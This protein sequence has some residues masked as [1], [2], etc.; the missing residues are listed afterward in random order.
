MPAIRTALIGLSATAKTSWAGDAHLPYLLSPIGRKHYDVVALL[1]SSVAAGEASKQHFKLHATV[2]TYGDPE[3]LAQDLDIDLVVCCTRADVH[4]PTIAPSL[5]AGK[6]AFIEWPLAENSDKARE[7]VTM[8][9][10]SGTNASKCIIGLQGRVAPPTLI[11][12]ELLTSGTIGT[13]LSSSVASFGHLLPRDSLPESLA[14]FADR[15]VG[16]NAIVI[17]NGHTLDYVHAVLGEFAN[18]DA[19]MQIQRPTLS[20]VDAE[21]NKS[22]SLA[23]SVPDLVSIHGSLRASTGDIKV[24]DGATLSQ[25]FRAGPPFKS[26][27]AVTWTINGTKGE[28]MI[29]VQGQYL[30]S[31]SVDPIT[32]LHHDHATNEVKEVQWDW[33]EWQKE[34]P[35]RARIIAEVYERYAEWWEGGKVE[36]RK[37]REWPSLEDAVDRMEE[38]AE[39]FG[40]FDGK[41]G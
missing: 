2:K 32:I 11:V 24:A 38:F 18:F 1:N 10:D 16:G 15:K 27:P 9:K 31:H 19:R 40:Q 35:V 6:I 7:L 30:H 39:M 28:L 21:D 20:L 29:T 17:E 33:S 13:V 26:Q 12:K 25:I 4:F 23:T 41:S 3:A 22:G 34:L 37:G 5:R 8:A 14:Y 36:V